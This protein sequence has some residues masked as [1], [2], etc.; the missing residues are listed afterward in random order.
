[1]SGSSRIVLPSHQSAEGLRVLET[2]RNQ[3]LRSLVSGITGIKCIRQHPAEVQPRA[4][5]FE[6]V[7]VKDLACHVLKFGKPVLKQN[8]M[9]ITHEY[10]MFGGVHPGLFCL[11]VRRGAS[12]V[13]Y[14]F[15]PDMDNIA[16]YIKDQTSLTDELSVIIKQGYVK[17]INYFP[18]ERFLPS[19]IPILFFAH[20]DSDADLYVIYL[21]MEYAYYQY[22]KVGVTLEGMSD[23]V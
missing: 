20:S 11:S 22:P 8:F 16:S 19:G 6:I 12:Q 4:Q 7:N 14:L 9:A 18:S 13:A 2:F 15:N 1:M 23:D 10:D 17:T 3:Q 5:A 21:I